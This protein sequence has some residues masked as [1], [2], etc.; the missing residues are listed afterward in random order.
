MV[1]VLFIDDDPKAQA[2]LAM[3]LEER[4]TVLPAL[5]AAEGVS[6]LAEREPDVVLLDIDL[7]DGDG[8]DLLDQILARP[9]APPVVML[10]GYADVQFVKRAIQ[11]GAYDYILKPWRKAHL[12]GTLRQAVQHADLRRVSVQAADGDALSELVG[13]SPPMREL[14]SL[15]TRYAAAD[16][17]VLIQGESGS[18]KELAAAA[19]H[20]LSPRQGGP[21]LAV[22]CG[23]IP[24]TLLETELFGAER[25]AFTDA[26]S[27]P[28]CFERANRGTIL[29]DEVGELAAEA[30][31]K[32]LRVLESKELVRVGGSEAVRLNLRVISATNKDLKKEVDRG[33]FREDLYYRLNV[34][35][36]RVP[37]LRERPE[38]IPLL[39]ACLL[40]RLGRSAV[41][42]QPDALGKLCAHS[43]PGNIRELR[44]VLERA[45]VVAD[46][47]RIR[48]RDILL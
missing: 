44:N 13:A 19:L 9:Y 39:A 40:G 31:V 25:G 42:L 24:S 18:G 16:A 21:L 5:T 12:E 17:P 46:D 41:C 32:L 35:P 3:V 11:A 33:S 26:V 36:L 45:S 38:D 1:R 29:L 23:A 4:Y 2:T 48:A 7:P 27:R 37:A 34:L 28:G 14:K 10:T 8:L 30:Q 15:I 6:L 43:W 47:G 20:R 22:N